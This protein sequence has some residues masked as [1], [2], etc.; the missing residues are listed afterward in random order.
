MG[1]MPTRW[2]WELFGLGS[3]YALGWL[4]IVWLI[5]SRP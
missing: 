1:R 3:V 5:T 2:K 4:V